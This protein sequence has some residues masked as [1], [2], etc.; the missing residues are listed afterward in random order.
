M[1]NS[2]PEI[3]GSILGVAGRFFAAHA[4]A[5]NTGTWSTQTWKSERR[6]VKGYS[7]GATLRVELRFDDNCRNGH[8][9]FSI[10]GDVV[11]PRGWEASGCLHAEIARVFPEL[12]PLIKWHLMSADGPMHYIGNTVY[13]ASNRDCHGLLAGE[14]RQIVN[15]RTGDLCWVRPALAA[16]H[17]NGP[18]CPTHDA[19]VKWEPMTRTGEG[20]AREFDYARSCAIWPEA[21]DE[22]LSA[23]ADE[24]RAMLEARAPA[25]CEAFNAAMIGAGF[26]W[27]PKVI[28]TI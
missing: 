24:L 21:T 28:D 4:W 3:A 16:Q 20:K 8:N 25:L 9:T 11:S 26:N 1:N 15:G 17:C 5:G 22:Q 2:V 18:E 23:P 14:V 19:I 27:E 13:H 10:V 7:K 6:T 12:A